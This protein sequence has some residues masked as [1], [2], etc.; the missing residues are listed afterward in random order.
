MR[1]GGWRTVSGG[2]VGLILAA[3][4]IAGVVWSCGSPSATP[5]PAPAQ[6][7]TGT[8]P[9]GGGQISTL[10][11]AAGDRLIGTAVDLP[12]LDEDPEYAS[13]LSRE[14]NAV[15]PE[16]ALKW[17]RVEPARGQYD[18]AAADEIVAFAQAHGQK[19]R[20]HTIVWHS[21]LPSWL[22]DGTFTP[23][24]LSDILQS[25]ITLEMGRYKGRIYAWDVVNEPFAEDGTLRDNIWRHGLGSGYI[26]DALGWAHAADPAAKLYINDFNIEGKSPKSDAMYDLVKSLKAQGV[27][28][29]GV[30]IQGHLS[31]QYPFPGDMVDNIRRFAQLGVEVAITELDVRMSL[32]PTSAHLTAQ[33]D[34][35]R[36]A[37]AACVA[38]SAC[39]G[40]TVWEFTDKYSWVPAFF[41]GEGAA[42]VYDRNLAP[43]PAYEAVKAALAAPAS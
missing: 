4:L 32:P 20:G 21:Q 28:I 27:P 2:P 19:I 35:Y 18:F 39:V 7:S 30:G 13:I 1:P 42:C 41:S 33:A 22:S 15:T 25:H 24:Q 14:F 34:Y 36:R 6:S 11:V 5:S 17:E 29:D 8:A 31:L 38:V 43:K 9:A 40:V 16:N 3:P 23:S 12:Q 26:A 10:R 37:M